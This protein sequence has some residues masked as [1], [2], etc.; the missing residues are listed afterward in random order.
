MLLIPFPFLTA[1]VFITAL[2][3]L[4]GVVLDQGE[5]P[6]R[7]FTAFIAMCAVQSLL[8]GFRHG[9]AMASLA[10]LLP[11]S[12]LL[13]PPLAWASFARPPINL[14]LCW[15]AVPAL[16]AV[17]AWWVLPLVIDVLVPIVFIGYAVLLLR[18]ALGPEAWLSWL[19]LGQMIVSAS[20]TAYLDF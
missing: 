13:I 2:L 10:P 17:A 15:H 14:S 11:V 19:R 9:Y 20:K 18:L 7:F 6:S 12:A 4:H 1:T 5:R 8:I 16:I 3:V